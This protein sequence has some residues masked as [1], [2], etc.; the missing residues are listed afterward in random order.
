VTG[1]YTASRRTYRNKGANR[2]L[3]DEGNEEEKYQVTEN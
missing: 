1:G 3:E 2:S